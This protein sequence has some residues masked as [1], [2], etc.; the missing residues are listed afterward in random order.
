[1]NELYFCVF[2]GT[3]EGRLI[4]DFLSQRHLKVDLYIATEYGEQ[5]VKN[6]ENINVYQKRL[7][8]NEMIN[9][10]QENKYSHIID[11]THPFAKIVSRNIVEAVKVCKLKHYR[12]IRESKKYENC[13]YVD[14]TLDAISILN[15]EEGNILLTTGS[16]DLEK[17]TQVK[18]YKERTFVRILPME[19]SLRKALELG[20]SNKNI[21]CMQ[22]PFSEELNVAMINSIKAKYLVTKESV[23]SGGFEEK[24]N[25][26]VKTGCKCIAIRK[27]NEDGVTL[28]ELKVLI[29]KDMK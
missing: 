26:C 8:K 18:N 7:G 11:A 1:M 29:E 12:I 14:N 19:D 20:F 16:K 9:L 27:P 23:T 21:I 2:G 28:E 13:I 3:T 24:V 22:G 4:A 17:F 25:S 6:I 5:F 10:F 15:G